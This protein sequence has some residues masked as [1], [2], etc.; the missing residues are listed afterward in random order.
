MTKK[1]TTW[2]LMQ[3]AISDNWLD[4]KYLL[5]LT[6]TTLNRLTSSTIV[7][8]ERMHLINVAR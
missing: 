1:I 2:T 7:L 3:L 8:I 5:R 6:R 4:N